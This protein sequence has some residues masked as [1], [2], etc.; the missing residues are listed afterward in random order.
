M[1]TYA[2][3]EGHFWEGGS[4]VVGT[5]GEGATLPPLDALRPHTLNMPKDKGSEWDHV[6]VAEPD[7]AEG[8]SKA[9]NECKLCH[10]KFP[11]RFCCSKWLGACL[12]WLHLPAMA[13]VHL[14]V[15]A[16][17]CCHERA[18]YVPF[19]GRLMVVCFAAACSCQRGL[20]GPRML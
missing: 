15:M 11:T 14:P 5:P 16:A 12:S 13:A 2:Y 8:E 6:T 4:Q 1:Y 7:E 9:K 19:T 18:P 3:L 17:V 20:C 10:H